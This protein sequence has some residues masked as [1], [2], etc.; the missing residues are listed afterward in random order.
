MKATASA[1]GM[2]LR[3]LR[4][5][6]A[7][8]RGFF[9]ADAAAGAGVRGMAARVGCGFVAIKPLRPADLTL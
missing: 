5:P 1:A 7:G 6:G 8:L 9:A 3:A 4:R 2:A